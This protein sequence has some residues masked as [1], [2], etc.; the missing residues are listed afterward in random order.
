MQE[1]V[2]IVA[3]GSGSRMQ[4]DLP[5]QFLTLGHKPVI[6]HTIDC[7]L[8][9]R[10][11]IRI[12]ICCPKDF[13]DYTQELLLEYDYPEGIAITEG[14]QTRFHSVKN[15]LGKITDAS[16]IVGIH[17]AARPLV[18]R[19]TIARCYNLAREKGNAIPVVALSE[20]IRKVENGRN[21]SQDRSLF[22]IVQTPQCFSTA[23]IKEA[24]K[25]EYSTA[26]TDDASVFEK[27]GHAIHLAEGN[28]EN[29]KI[30][31]PADL[32]IAEALLNKEP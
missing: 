32:H 4:S 22:R 11:D 14:G 26:F 17:D 6:L 24:F 9:Y 29:I 8:S 30:T 23:L 1:Y 20:S 27:A 21:E 13:M 10:P 15:G 18:S 2:I 12:I 16:S 3:G 28:T 31:V 19:D 25:Q 5:K 7:F